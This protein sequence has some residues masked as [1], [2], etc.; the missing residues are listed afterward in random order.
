MTPA[1]T[2]HT[3]HQFNAKSGKTLGTFGTNFG[4]FG[5]RFLAVWA[6]DLGSL[7]L[8]LG[9]VHGAAASRAVVGQPPAAGRRTASGTLKCGRT[10]LGLEE[11]KTYAGKKESGSKE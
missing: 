5:D 7:K 4:F 8:F 10:R 1:A 2:G 3:L 9:F 6:V 11:Q